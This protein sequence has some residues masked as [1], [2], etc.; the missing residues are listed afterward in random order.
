MP[1][2]CRKSQ[3]VVK[4]SLL[5]N[6]SRPFHA[7]GRKSRLKSGTSIHLKQLRGLKQDVQKATGKEILAALAACTED[8][9]TL[10]C[11][12]LLRVFDLRLLRW[13]LRKQSGARLKM[14]D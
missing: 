4:A 14:K 8:A 5:T 7:A 3:R 13:N 11:V 9:T 2:G 1:S 12:Q 10:Q 6:T